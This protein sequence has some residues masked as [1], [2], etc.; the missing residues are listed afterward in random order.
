MRKTTTSTCVCYLEHGLKTEE[1]LT[2]GQ[3]TTRTTLT[4]WTER[5]GLEG[6][7][8]E[9]TNGSKESLV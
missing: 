1:R 7:L 3:V 9:E 2:H 8:I 5:V 6:A 4:K